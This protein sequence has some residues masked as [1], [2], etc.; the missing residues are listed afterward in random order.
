MS[1]EVWFAIPSA[2]EGMARRTLPVWK[3]RGYR[4][5]LLQD[6]FRFDV[7]EADVVVRP[8]RSYRGWPVSVNFLC[9]H[10]L[11]R[12][13]PVVVTGGDDMEPDPR[14]A[15]EI[16]AAFRAKFPDLFGVLQPTGDDYPGTDKICG[17]PWLG[18]GW[19]DRAYSGVG[20]LWPQYHHFYADEELLNV[21]G[22][23]GVLWQAREFAQYHH[24]RHRTGN[25][26]QSHPHA[27]SFTG[28]WDEDKITF[29]QRRKH[30]WPCAKPLDRWETA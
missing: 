30:G 6:Q 24:H 27:G 19:V 21:A 28:S 18:R 8:W 1:E 13:C 14:P 9:R 3:A 5:A 12:D 22:G 11:P 15:A 4:I 25:E 29:E 17:S 10:V 20:P 7:P 23:L 26:K 2:N 16:L